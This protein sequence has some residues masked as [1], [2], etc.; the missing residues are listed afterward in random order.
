MKDEPNY[1]LHLA[2]DGHIVL[3]TDWAG[4]V[5]PKYT[6]DS[7]LPHEK[8]TAGQ[9]VKKWLLKP[10][11]KPSLHCEAGP[12]KLNDY[13]WRLLSDWAPKE[14]IEL[15]ELHHELREKGIELPPVQVG[16][17][18]PYTLPNPLEEHRLGSL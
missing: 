9:F 16:P 13:G 5:G 6:R 4:T 1:I 11:G 12:E 15:C 8:I 2:N 18:V 3:I 14:W 7:I 17:S 10:G